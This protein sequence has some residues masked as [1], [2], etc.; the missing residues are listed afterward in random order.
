[1]MFQPLLVGAGSS[2]DAAP[3]T[4]ILSN[5]LARPYHD[6]GWCDSR[7]CSLL[8]LQPACSMHSASK[9]I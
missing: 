2:Q 1:M 5:E 8:L 7:M 3:Y 9:A 6:L 4:S